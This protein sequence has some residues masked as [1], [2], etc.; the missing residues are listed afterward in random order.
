[1]DNPYK[2]ATMYTQDDDKHTKYTTQ[3]TKT[4]SNIKT[5][6]EHRHPRKLV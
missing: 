4:T 5:G 6:G 3:K 2:S 1:M